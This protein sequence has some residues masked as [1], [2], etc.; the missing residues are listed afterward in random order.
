MRSLGFGF[1]KCSHDS[2]SQAEVFKECY[3]FSELFER[4]QVKQAAIVSRPKAVHFAVECRFGRQ[5]AKA[6]FFLAR[7]IVGAT[8]ITA[9]G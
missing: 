7:V 8:V 3:Q 1:V 9:E 2:S 4:L 5:Q 6:K